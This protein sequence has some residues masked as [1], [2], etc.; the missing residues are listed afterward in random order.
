[1]E[2]ER[3]FFFNEFVFYIS[4]YIKYMNFKKFRELAPILKIYQKYIQDD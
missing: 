3:H 1:M 2:Q 4:K